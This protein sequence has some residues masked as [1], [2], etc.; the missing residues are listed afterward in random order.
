[1]VRG[2]VFVLPDPMEAPMAVSGGLARMGGVEA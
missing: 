2:I 1:M